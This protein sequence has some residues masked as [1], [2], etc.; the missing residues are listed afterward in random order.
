[1]T[2]NNTARL[3]GF[4]YLLL[5]I[6]GIFYLVYVPSQLIDWGSAE[7]TASNIMGSKFLFRSSIVAG[8]I[9]SIC[10]LILPFVLYELL[11]SVNKTVAV[12]MI[13]LSV[14]SVPVSLFNMIN[15]IDVLT[16]LS[17]AQYLTV[18]EVEQLHSQV[19]LLLKSYNNGISLVQI[20]WGLWLFPFGYLVF[21]SGFLPKLLGICLMLG[22]IE[23]LIRFFGVQLYP[24]AEIPS[25]IGYAHSIGEIGICLWLLI[26]GV[27]DKQLK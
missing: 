11:K 5:V 23:Y 15:K 3:A 10:F 13:V 8:V 9:S 21:K 22:C 6:T 14:V 12:W 18:F 1:M 26:M 19:M 4:I 20:F 25:F 27:K 17:G 24:D 2:K 7:F 16:L